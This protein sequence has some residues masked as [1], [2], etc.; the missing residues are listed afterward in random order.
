MCW[1]A[2]KQMF[3]HTCFGEAV[4]SCRA[5][6]A[7]HAPRPRSLTHVTDSNVV[8]Q[9]TPMLLL[10]AGRHQ[11]WLEPYQPRWQRCPT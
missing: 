5:A 8:L 1:L 10:S 2:H 3:V 4:Q 11:G 6:I 9:P 7:L